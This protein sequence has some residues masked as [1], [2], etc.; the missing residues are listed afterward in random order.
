M[1]TFLALT[2]TLAVAAA[3]VA[4][5]DDDDNGDATPTPEASESPTGSAEDTPTPEPTSALENVCGTNPDPA[6]DE[7]LAVAEPEEGAE[8]TSP[9]TI[10]GEAP[11]F[12]GRVWFYAYDGEGNALIDQGGSTNFGHLDE[13]FEDEV[14]FSVNKATPACLEVYLFRPEQGGTTDV[15]QIPVLLL[16]DEG[17]TP[18]ETATPGEITNVCPENPDPADEDVVN[19][20]GPNPGDM[21]RSPFAVSGQAAAFEASIQVTLLDAEGGVVADQP[22]MTNEGQTLAPFEELIEFSV[23]EETDGC[24]QVYMLS[25]QDGEPVNIAQIPLVLLPPAE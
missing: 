22:G 4:C 17:S 12:D 18:A 9:F 15:V 24:L 14:E 6:T 20:T 10:E 19:I 16:A 3:L 7:E 11:E 25:A 2:L 23:E 1:K 8:L 21:V 13:P 5:G